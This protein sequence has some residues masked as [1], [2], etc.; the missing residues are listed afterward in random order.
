MSTPA[1]S[2]T[3]TATLDDDEVA[4]AS[5]YLF[6]ADPY[7]QDEEAIKRHQARAAER[8]QERQRAE[9]ATDGADHDAEA[10]RNGV[11]SP[12]LPQVPGHDD[13]EDGATQQPRARQQRVYVR[14]ARDAIQVSRDSAMTRSPT[15][16]CCCDRKVHAVSSRQFGADSLRA[17]P[18]CRC[19][20]D[21]RGSEHALYRLL[22]P[23]RGELA[24]RAE[25]SRRELTIA[26]RTR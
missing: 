18:D 16:P 23:V 2:S 13:D 22:H 4:S 10:A 1:P 9:R 8:E 21:E 3:A 19:T 5:A 15:H 24:E 20:Q 17:P 25:P 7:P 12:P 26:A 11:T 14:P 6:S